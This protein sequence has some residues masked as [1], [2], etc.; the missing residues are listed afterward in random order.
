MKQ[1]VGIPACEM[2]NEG[3]EITAKRV[4]LIMYRK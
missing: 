3:L 4:V 2:E 1:N